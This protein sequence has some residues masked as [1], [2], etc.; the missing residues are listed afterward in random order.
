MSHLAGLYIHPV[1]SCASI[2]L[3]RALLT[4]WGLEWDRHWMVVDVNDGFVTQRTYPDMA[5][6]VPA[7]ED[8]ALVL[9]T[10]GMPDLTLPLESASAKTTRTVNVWDDAFA[11]L[12][13]G[14][15]AARW[16][17]SRFDSTL[18]LVRFDPAVQRTVSK[19]WTREYDRVTQFADGFPMLVAGQGSLDDL[20]ERLATKGAPAI[21]MNRFRP[22]VV[23][24]GLDP[25]DED[26]IDTLS[27]GDDD[28]VV[29]KLAK[30]CARCPIPT[31]DQSTGLRDERWPHEPIDTLSTY[32]ANPIV[33]G[34]ITFGQNAIAIQGEGQWLEIGAPVQA[35]WN[36]A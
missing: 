20:N 15:A 6:I 23:I 24:A 11:A 22:N 21:P 28:A 13:E 5:R 30:P 27:I 29:L 9:R 1:K 32:R 14:D 33:N 8:D 4:R 16:F 3:E 17:S 36:F 12:D 18:R 31:I 2:A 34:G 26:F 7:F 35:E 19:K 10:D 25:Y